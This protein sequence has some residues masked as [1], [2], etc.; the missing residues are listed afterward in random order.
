MY[1][2]NNL[3]LITCDNSCICDFI[4]CSIR[5]AVHYPQTADSCVERTNGGK[6]ENYKNCKRRILNKYVLY[7]ISFCNIIFL[8]PHFV[9]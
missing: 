7:I 9:Y 5:A 6:N 2:L 1:L 8:L 3:L 4:K